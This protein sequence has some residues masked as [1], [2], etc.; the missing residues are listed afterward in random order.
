MSFGES[1][2]RDGR[3]GY[4]IPEL[5]VVVAVLGILAAIAIPAMVGVLGSSKET[6]ANNNLEYLNQAVWKYGHA[7]AQ[8][9]N[10]AGQ[11]AAVLALLKTR[12]A[13]MP[14]SP[15]VES[16]LSTNVSSDASTYRANWNGTNFELISPETGGTGLNLLQMYQ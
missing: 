11:T 1:C 16:N 5:M 8:I 12:D 13:S 10:P 14:G 6:T 2:P 3:R 4:S 15:Y 9:A 7:G